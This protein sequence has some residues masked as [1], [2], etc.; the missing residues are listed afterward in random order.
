MTVVFDSEL[1]RQGT[2]SDQ[3]WFVGVRVLVT[4]NHRRLTCVLRGSP[5]T[6]SVNSQ[7]S[8][9]TMTTDRLETSGAQYPP[10]VKPLQR[11]QSSRSW[12]TSQRSV[13]RYD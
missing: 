13:G 12:P 9:S 5:P 8:V 10:T 6:G 3:G 7:V 2:S 11:C 1:V 4:L